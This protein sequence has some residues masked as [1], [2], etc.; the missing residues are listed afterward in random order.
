M[1]SEALQAFSSL[2][3]NMSAMKIGRSLQTLSIS[4][5]LARRLRKAFDSFKTL[6]SSFSVDAA[7]KW[8]SNR[9]LSVIFGTWAAFA[10]REQRIENKFNEKGASLHIVLSLRRYQKRMQS[11][12]LQRCQSVEKE[13]FGV[14]FY[15]FLRLLTSFERFSRMRSMKRTARNLVDSADSYINR[16]RQAEYLGENNY[17]CHRTCHSLIANSTNI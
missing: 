4:H 15:G 1:K 5:C 11:Q 13:Q 16:R 6:L 10:H 9:L 3:L 12:R 2:A 17:L 14:A 8:F 7:R